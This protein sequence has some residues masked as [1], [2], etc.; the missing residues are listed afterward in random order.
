[1]SDTHPPSPSVVVGI[2]GSRSAVNAALWAVDEAVKRDL[3][4]RLVYVI[5]PP[6]GPT[7]SEA[8]ARA[9]A[10]ADIA[11]R[12][13]FVAIESTEKPVKIE[14]EILQG[15]PTDKLLEASRVAALACVGSVGIKHATAGTIG[16]TA[17]ELATRAHCPVA[18]VR[19][20]DT[21]PDGTKAVVVEVDKS[22]DGEAILQRAIDE[23]VLR[24]APLVVIALWQ[25]NVTEVHD[26]HAVAEQSRRLRADLNRRLAR[27]ARKYPDLDVRPVVAH[28]SLLNY[29]SRHAQS[30][31]LVVVGLRRLHGLTEMVGPHG[32][33]A[34]QGSDCAV[35]VCPSTGHL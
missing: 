19:G 13:A 6:Q 32:H 7:N 31:Q 10:S 27:T 29:L 12:H 1:M 35:L 5:E 34:L 8:S 23:A 22:A 3:P 30:T 21:A 9:L 14:V 4:L 18:V 26:T 24:H 28:G 17:A 16:S 33:A 11:V 25:S 20:F 15:R 2:D